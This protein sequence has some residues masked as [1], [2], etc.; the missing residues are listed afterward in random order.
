[1]LT[2]MD[3]RNIETD[4]W[5]WF[6]DLELNEKSLNEKKSTKEMDLCFSKELANESKSVMFKYLKKEYKYI[7]FNFIIHLFCSLTIIGVIKYIV[8]N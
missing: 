6:I 8:S 2:I 7:V 1:M 3:T 5:G 4:Q